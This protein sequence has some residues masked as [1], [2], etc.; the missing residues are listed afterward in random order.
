VYVWVIVDFKE[1]LGVISD[2]VNN[3]EFV[4]IDAE[5]SGCLC[6]YYYYRLCDYY[7]LSQVLE[8]LLLY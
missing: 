2:A 5:F 1:S 8:V 6:D 4:A 3:A 7:T